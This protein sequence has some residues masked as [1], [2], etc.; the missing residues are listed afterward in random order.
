MYEQARENFAAL[1]ARAPLVLDDTP[2][3]YFYRLRMGTHEQTGIGGCFSLDEYE[4]DVIR[5]H[6]SLEAALAA[7][8]FPALA[9]QLRLFRSIATMDAKA[10]L[11]PL[12]DQRPSWAKAS[13]L[14]RDWQLNALADRLAK[15][16][17]RPAT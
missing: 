13:A 5:K 16:A 15:L 6:G 17:E 10:P 2:S 7:G 9:E 8:R 3:L 14:A 11:P 12:K 4:S 1:R